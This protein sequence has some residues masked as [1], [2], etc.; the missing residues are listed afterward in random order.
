LNQQHQAAV[1]CCRSS[2]LLLPKKMTKN[3]HEQVAGVKL[4][5]T[6]S[7]GKYPPVIHVRHSSPAEYEGVVVV[8]L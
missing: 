1:V 2:F 6:S 8:S 7:I 3:M 5:D 4:R